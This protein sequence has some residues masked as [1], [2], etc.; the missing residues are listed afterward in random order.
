MSIEY[1]SVKEKIS[2]AQGANPGLTNNKHQCA[3]KIPKIN[4]VT[5]SNKFKKHFIL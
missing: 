2:V 1:N 5:L 4:M 3:V